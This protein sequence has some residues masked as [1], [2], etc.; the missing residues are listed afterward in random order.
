M[1][2]LNKL[3]FLK[4]EIKELKDEIKN[5]SEIS[6]PG[7]SGMPHSNKKSNPIEQFFMKKEKLIEKLIKKLEKYIE[8]LNRIENFI[9]NI[10]DPEIRTIARL[11]YID[12]LK[13]EDIGKQVHLDRSVCSKKLT[14]YVG[15]NYGK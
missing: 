5:L 11:R 3:Y 2:D 1:K 6:S 10:D 13:W 7:L 9:E 4:I 12:N 15:E 14:K 8:E